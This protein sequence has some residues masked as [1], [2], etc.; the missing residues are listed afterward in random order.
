MIINSSVF[1]L[2]TLQPP[3]R[4]QNLLAAHQLASDEQPAC[5]NQP[6]IKTDSITAL[7]HNSSRSITVCLLAQQ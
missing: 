6:H 2:V 1:L 4:G 5:D 3:L 7:F